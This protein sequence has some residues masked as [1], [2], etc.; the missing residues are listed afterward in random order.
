MA[1]IQL[2]RDTTVNWLA[3]DPVL[4]EGE[5]ALDTT[6][7]LLYIGDGSTPFSQLPAFT[8]DNSAVYTKTEADNLLA[9]KAN[10]ADTYTK[11]EV[12]AK[13][14]EGEVATLGDIGDVTVTNAQQND[15]LEW[16]GLAWVNRQ[17]LVNEDTIND[18]I[19]ERRIVMSAR[20]DVSTP[21]AGIWAGGT[22][23]KAD[24]NG[25]LGWHFASDNDKIGWEIFTQDLNAEKVITMASLRSASFLLRNAG[26]K[27]PYFS[28]Y[29]RRKNDGQD[30]NAQYRSRFNYVIN[31][32]DSGGLTATRLLTTREDNPMYENV[33]HRVMTH[34][35]PNSVGP[36][37]S[38]E[39]VKNI[40][41]STASG[42]GVGVYDFVGN[43]FII[44]TTD[45]TYCIE[46]RATPSV[47]NMGRMYYADSA[48]NPIGRINGDFW[49]DSVNGA[50]HIWTGSWTAL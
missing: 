26:T 49:Y 22:A 25:R 7:D 37:Q 31:V 23:P 15:I 46:L 27:Y 38:D 5:Q 24:P 4:A 47:Q 29:T 21:Y 44:D 28:V 13:V 41:I 8:G 45:E 36:Q 12:D 34:D 35:V 9:L 33:E 3:A 30:A 48:P 17:S 40:T 50:L 16:N 14:S 39:I 20:V 32:D 42:S 2:R 18:L 6:T 19:N 10:T 43:E 11:A 1:R